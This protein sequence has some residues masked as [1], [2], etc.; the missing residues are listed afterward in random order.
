MHT[1]NG[2]RVLRIER[3]RLAKKAAKGLEVFNS[4][5]TMARQLI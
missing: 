1:V 5:G 4:S 3:I 2:R